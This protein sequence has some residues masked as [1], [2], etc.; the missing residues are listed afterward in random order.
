MAGTSASGLDVEIRRDLAEHGVEVTDLADLTQRGGR[1]SGEIAQVLVGWLPRTMEDPSL[2]EKVVRQLSVPWARTQ[3]LQPML[4]LFRT[5]PGGSPAA[6]ARRWAVGNGLEVLAT[7]A[8]F[9]EMAA[10]AADPAYGRSRQ[11]VV[12]W[13]GKSKQHRERAVDVLLGLLDQ[14][15]VSGHAVKALA[16]LKDPRSLDGLRRMTDD[17][18]AWVRNSAKRTIQ[19]LEA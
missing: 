19:R 17:S 11:M 15:D 3:A 10:L 9:D 7:D 18:R 2:Q 4:D 14:H 5:A 13:L 6:D 12:L 8:V 1:Y 16:K